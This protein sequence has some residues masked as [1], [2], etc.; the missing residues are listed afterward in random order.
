[1]VVLIHTPTGSV[2]EVCL[3][4]YKHLSNVSFWSAFPSLAILV[5]NSNYDFDLHFS[6]N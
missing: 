5:G 6:D 3:L 4:P 2:G 1:M